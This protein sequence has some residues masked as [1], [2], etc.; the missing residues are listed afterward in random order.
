V[1]SPDTETIPESC[2]SRWYFSCNI[3]CKN[4]VTRQS[5][6]IHKL[7]YDEKMSCLWRFFQGLEHFSVEIPSLST[8]TKWVAISFSRG[9]L[10]LRDLTYTYMSLSSLV[11]QLVKNLPAIQ[12]TQV[13]SPGQEDPLE[14]KMAIHSSTPLPEDFHEQTSWQLTVHGIPKSPT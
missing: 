10:Q 5:L 3:I 6:I 11:A 12:E 13:R 14:K 7:E 4:E 8:R 1:I 2:N 9:P